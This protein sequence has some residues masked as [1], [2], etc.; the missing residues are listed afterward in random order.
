MHS[1][2]L[3]MATL[4]LQEQ[5]WVVTLWSARLEYMAFKKKKFANPC[6]KQLRFTVTK[7]FLNSILYLQLAL[8]QHR[9]ELWRST[10]MQISFNKY[11]LKYC[12][13]CDWLN[14]WMQNCRNGSLTVKF[15]MNFR[16]CGRLVPLTPP[17]FK[18]Q[19]HLQACTIFR[20]H[21]FR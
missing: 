10:Y 5:S 8:K 21:F 14:P 1:L 12:A 16:L 15:Y 20:S 17:P 19:L 9:F 3:S 6:I 11:V 13:I 7:N 2:M 18:G 4:V